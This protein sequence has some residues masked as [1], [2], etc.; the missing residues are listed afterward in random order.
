MNLSVSAIPCSGISSG[1]EVNIEKLVCGNTFHTSQADVFPLPEKKDA[2]S[3][4]VTE[5]NIGRALLL[6]GPSCSAI[7]W[8]A[9]YRK[10]LPVP[11]AIQISSTLRSCT[12][13]TANT[14]TSL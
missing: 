3:H 2:V 13:D 4:P 14:T 12:L 8:A 11:N 1:T 6:C 5:W 10:C 7:E 9:R